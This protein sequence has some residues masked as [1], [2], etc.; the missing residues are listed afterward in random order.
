MIDEFL[1][2]G[3]MILGPFILILFSLVALGSIFLRGNPL[4]GESLFTRIC[5]SIFILMIMGALWGS[6]FK[7]CGEASF[8]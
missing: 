1:D 3:Y 4:P 7:R 8:P 6:F 5:G 2:K